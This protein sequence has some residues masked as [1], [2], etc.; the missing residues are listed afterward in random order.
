[1]KL[2]RR[3]IAPVTV[4]AALVFAG[5]A[6][7]SAPRSQLTGFAC[8]HGLDPANRTVS[9]QAVMR[10]RAGTRHLAVRFS[11]IER[12]SGAPAQNVHAGDLGSWVTP[13]NATMGQRPGDVWRVDKS[14]LNLDAPATYQYKVTFHW[15]GAGGR[16]LGSAVRTTRLCRERELR[17]DLLVKTIAVTPVAGHPAEDSYTATIANRGLTGA[18]PFE[19]LFVGGDGTTATPKTISFLGAGQHREVS[20]TGPACAMAGPPTVTADAAD[21]VDDYN[22]ANNQL[23]ASCPADA[24]P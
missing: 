13:E 11:L 22:R 1:M 17:P 23:T 15:I 6:A 7:A 10:P 14:V 16:V 2:V 24:A 3:S 8:Q 5:A 21:Q 12:R 9:V 18:G 4:V 20:F 19:V